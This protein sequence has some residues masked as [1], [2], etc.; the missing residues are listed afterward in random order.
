[1]GTRNFWFVTANAAG[2]PHAMPVWAVSMPDR[3]RWGAG[4]ASS[5]RK[6]RNMQANAKIMVTTENSVDCVSVE[7]Q[8]IALTGDQAEPLVAA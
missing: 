4:F 8:S 7:G 3:Q 2:R 5:A 6:V 1:M